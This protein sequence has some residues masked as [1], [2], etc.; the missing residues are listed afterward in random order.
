MTAD[1]IPWLPGLAV[2]CLLLL[3]R[4]VVNESRPQDVIIGVGIGAGIVGAWLAP[5]GK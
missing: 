4:V 2:A 3:C 1:R 5:K